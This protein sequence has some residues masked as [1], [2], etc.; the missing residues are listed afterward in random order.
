ML[1]FEGVERMDE[2]AIR[3]ILT[4]TLV[5]QLEDWQ[6]LELATALSAAEAL[7]METGERIRWKGSIAGG[8]EIVTVGRYRIRWQNA[9]PK[10]AVEHLDPSEAMI[11]ET[12]EALRAGM[13][14][15]RADVSVRDAATGIDVAH[16]ECKWFGSPLSASAAIVDAISQL[17]R[18]CRDS[19]PESVEQAR[20]MLRDCAVVCSG[21]SGFEE[22]T[23]GAKPIGLTDFSGLAS[24]ALIAWAARLH[25][26]LAANPV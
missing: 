13:G 14:L 8:S 4:S 26:R 21:L 18:Y 24:G 15:A 10:R 11:R 3:S 23:D 2:D 1:L 6:K 7:A 17:V 25:R 22:S 20:T 9:L 5:A 12:A 19:R 16:F